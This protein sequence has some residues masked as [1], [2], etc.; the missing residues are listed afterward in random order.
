MLCDFLC[1]LS[2][3]IAD[4][5]SGSEQGLMLLAFLEEALKAVG[6]PRFPLAS[7][8]EHFQPEY[9]P[10]LS[11]LVAMDVRTVALVCNQHA[12]AHFREL[13]RL[14]KALS[15]GKDRGAALILIGRLFFEL[16]GGACLQDGF[17]PLVGDVIRAAD[18]IQ[19]DY[20]QKPGVRLLT[21]VCT[22]SPSSSAVVAATY[23]TELKSL[24][25]K[26]ADAQLLLDS[27][28]LIQIICKSDPSSAVTVRSE[29]FVDMLFDIL[30]GPK[31][32]DTI[33]ILTTQTLLLLFTP[34]LNCDGGASSMHLPQHNGYHLRVTSSVVRRAIASLSKP[35]LAAAMQLMLAV[36]RNSL[37]NAD[38]S[39]ILQTC[40]A[41]LEIFSAHCSDVELVTNVFLQCIGSSKV[42]A[43]TSVDCKLQLRFLESLRSLCNNTVRQLCCD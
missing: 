11:L 42:A 9:L 20:C 26:Q 36:T 14:P 37:L 7:M 4:C 15:S 23:S 41:A 19:E 3:M 8:L 6:V 12:F 24:I 29:N 38:R 10:V 17:M 28:G 27:L 43:A 13:T 34:L 5:G 35:L 21:L 1:T 25:L 33:L 2:N 31:P 40:I 16:S 32:E 18:C 39:A 30:D 22:I